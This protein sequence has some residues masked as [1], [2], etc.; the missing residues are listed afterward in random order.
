MKVGYG[1][2]ALARGV[3]TGSVDGIGSYTREL[4]NEMLS[5]GRVRLIP[6]SFGV[7]LQEEL[8]GG[9][10]LGEELGSFAPSVAASAVLPVDFCGTKGLR[11][12]IDLFHSTDHLVPRLKGIPVLATIMDAIPLS[13]P[14]WVRQRLH[15]LKAWLWQRSVNW[16][17]HIV[18]ISEYSKREI[19]THFNISEND[20]SVVPLGVD[21][22][23]FVPIEADRRTRVLSRYNLPPHFFLFVG[24]LQPRKNLGRILQA[25]SALPDAYRK[26]CPLVVAGRAGW[27]CDAEIAKLREMEAMGHA[28]WLDYL[29]DVEVRALMQSALSLVFPSLCEGFGLPV[30]EAFA[31]GLPVITSNSTS[32]PEV[33]GEAALLVDPEDVEAIANGMQRILEDSCLVDALR[34]RGLVRARQLSW[35]TCAEK[36]FS[37]YQKLIG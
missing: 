26:E 35:S 15:A 18:T 7:A 23:Y 24:T 8:I 36:T 25:H 30:L 9:A 17:D 11:N 16:A 37:L 20:I 29:P 6:V 3:R 22:R 32:L 10:E 1:V 14:Q 4:G 34:D 12:R 13:H 28:C 19:S 21:Q 33:A 5:R 27:N 31:S 2:T